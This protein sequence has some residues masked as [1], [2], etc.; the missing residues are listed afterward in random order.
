MAEI[1]RF[2]LE[3]SGAAAGPGK[4]LAFLRSAIGHPVEI[5]AAPA[6][7]VDTLRLQ[8]LVSAARQW[9]AAAQPLS[10][11]NMAPSFAPAYIGWVSTRRSSKVR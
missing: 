10:L 1:R 5:D 3:S 8:I 2:S 11:V 4:L 7:R 9:D 6:A